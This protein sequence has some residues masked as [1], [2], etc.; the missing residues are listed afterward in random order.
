MTYKDKIALE[1][2]WLSKQPRVIFLGEGVINADRIYKTLNGVPLDKCIEMPIAENLIVGSA[3]GLAIA[4][5]KPVVIF[6]RMDFMLIAADAIINHIALIPKMSGDRVKL[7]IIIRATIGSKN[8]KFDCGAQH[9]HDF[10]HIFSPYILTLD[11]EEGIYKHCYNRNEPVLIVD[12]KD[13]YERDNDEIDN[14]AC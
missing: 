6:Q 3:I 9:N 13:L 1:M 4:G 10:R 2:E 8:K 5:Y 14:T 11:Y 7:P 12:D